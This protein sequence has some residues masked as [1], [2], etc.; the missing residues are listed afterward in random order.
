MSEDSP[1]QDDVGA[2]MALMKREID[3]LQRSAMKQQRRWYQVPSI[4]IAFAALLFSFGT[5]A[6][7]YYRTGQQD[8][9]NARLELRSLIQR[10]YALP[11]EDIRIAATYSN[12]PRAVAQISSTLNQEN[13]L[14]AQRA[15]EVID[16]IPDAVSSVEYVTVA[17]A[18]AMSGISERAAEFMKCAIEKAS[19]TGTL[20]SA[21][22]SYGSYLFSTGEI[23]AARVEMQKALAVLDEHANPNTYFQKAMEI[24]IELRWATLE[25]LTGDEIE[26]QRHLRKANAEVLKLTP[27][28]YTEKLK[29]QIRQVDPISQAFPLIGGQYYTQRVDSYSGHDFDTDKVSA[30]EKILARAKQELLR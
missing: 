12:N 20:A 3:A 21:R 8:I 16:S 4:I 25:R 9:H 23:V 30:G 28:P 22:M 14:I 5:T 7:S 15:V 29:A 24:H 2:Q 1:W 17:T 19:S 13:I 27:A 18:L 6:V 26:A 10:L 11:L